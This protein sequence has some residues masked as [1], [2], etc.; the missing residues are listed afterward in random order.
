MIAF[1]VTS[2]LCMLHRKKCFWN[3]YC[4][5]SHKDITKMSINM[6]KCEVIL[7]WPLSVC[8]SILA[9]VS[10]SDQLKIERI[11]EVT[12]GKSILFT[13]SILSQT[14]CRQSSWISSLPQTFFPFQKRNG[15]L[16]F[17]QYYFLNNL[18]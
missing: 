11:I 8:E 16:L 14:W 10:H 12:R 1:S 9:G 13:P 15:S 7:M 17:F 18:L 2:L 4:L 6:Q 5:L 3:T